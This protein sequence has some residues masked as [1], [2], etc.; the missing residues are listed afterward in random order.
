MK[1]AGDDRMDNDTRLWET[2]RRI[3]QGLFNHLETMRSTSNYKQGYWRLASFVD[4][5]G[6]KGLIEEALEYIQT[7]ARISDI[8]V[9]KALLSACRVYKKERVGRLAANEI[10]DEVWA[11]NIFA[12]KY[13]IW[14]QFWK[15]PKCKVFLSLSSQSGAMVRSEM[16]FNWTS[17]L[18]FS[19]SSF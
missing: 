17:F 14:V 15:K 12:E 4:T 3:G 11:N 1:G 16:V 13:D 2:G 19:Q 9:W 6:R 5:L 8:V 18:H 7:K 10:I